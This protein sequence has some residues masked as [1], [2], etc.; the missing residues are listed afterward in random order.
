MRTETYGV[1]DQ[2]RV[3]RIAA[4][5]WNYECVANASS[6]ARAEAIMAEEWAKSPTY[7]YVIEH[8]EVRYGEW[9]RPCGLA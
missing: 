8:R 2:W 7:R 6:E 3:I 5:G 9:K 1:S 4:D